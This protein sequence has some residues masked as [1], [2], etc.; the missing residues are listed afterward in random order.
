MS[1]AINTLILKAPG[2]NCDYETYHAFKFVGG[3]PQILHINEL[4]KNENLFNKFDIVVIP[5]GFSYG[6]DISAG[7]V[8]ANEIKFKLLKN[9]KKFIARKKPVLGICNGFQVLVKLGLL[10]WENFTQSVTLTY[11]D[12][13]RYECRWVYLKVNKNNPSK[14]IKGLPDIVY[15]PVAHAEGKFIAKN[16]KVLEKIRKNHQIVFQ[17][18]DESGNTDV[19]YPFNPNGSDL[20]IAGI[21]NEH[22]NIIGLMPHPERAILKYN[23]PTWTSKEHIDNFAIQFFLN[24]VDY[25]RNMYG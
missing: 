1:K 20:N 5:G 12:S 24:I 8:L 15:W 14:F 9:L 11:N 16:K 18:S 7:K 25:A 19:G 21:T 22:G 6:D 17:Y 2:I 23:H 10:P 4:I 13:N 3:N